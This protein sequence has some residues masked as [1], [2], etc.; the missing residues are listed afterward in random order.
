MSDPDTILLEAEAAMEKALDYLKAE[1]KGVRTG[2][3]SPAM[4]EFLK[5]EAYGSMTDLKGLASINVPEPTQL[6]IKPFD[7]TLVHAIKN[8]ID[9][10]GMGVNPM[11]EG[12]ALRI[13]LPPMSQERR[14][15]EAARIK[16]M[17]EEQKV[18]MRNAR[19]DANKHAD[20]LKN[21]PAKHVPEDEIE[22]LKT[23]IQE[24]L[25]KYEADTDKRLEEKTKEIMTI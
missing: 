7:S 11:V 23:E 2:R 5:V 16:K 18:I 20:G 17:A 4:V 24:L 12:K 9:K 10:S 8:A 19:R 25:K 1:F 21:N 6:L 3:A 15:K 14:Q 22:Q 13:N